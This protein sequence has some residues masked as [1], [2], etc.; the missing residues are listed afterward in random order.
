MSAKKRA[1]GQ[2]AIDAVVEN[3]V[4]F[5]KMLDD[6][7][8][9]LAFWQKLH[10]NYVAIVAA[11]QAIVDGEYHSVYAG[12]GEKWSDTYRLRQDQQ[13]LAECAGVVAALKA[14]STPARCEGVCEFSD[15]PHHHA[16]ALS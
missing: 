4:T 3:E 5:A 16:G 15:E 14:L 6:V 2:A 9:R 10:L 12:R 11:D 1:R 7:P 8:G 13:R